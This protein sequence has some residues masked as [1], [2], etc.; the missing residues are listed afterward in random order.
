MNDQI[1]SL[2]IAPYL[3]EICKNLKNS[4]SRFLILTAETAAG[5]STAVPVSLL[6]N[7]SGK[8]LMLEPRRLAVTAIADRVSNLIGEET[9]NT[10]GYRL[11]LE[12]K[13][14]SLTRLEIVTEAILTRKLQSDP[15]LEDINV[16]VIDE[17]HERSIHADLAL[18]FLKETMQLRDDLYVII[19]SA[20]LDLR[21]LAEFCGN[22]TP[23]MSVPGRNFPVNVEYTPDRSVVSC[24]ADCLIN[25]KQHRTIL[26]FLPGLY[27]INKT[28]SQLAEKFS[29]DELQILILHSSVPL[30]EQRKI[31]KPN[32]ADMPVRVILS[33]SI[34]ETSITVPDVTLVI[35]SGLC[36][37][38]RINIALGMNQ[39]VTVPSSQF[40]AEQRTGRAGRVQ[41]GECIRLWD[42]TEI[43]PL[44]QE[45][46][47]LH[48]DISQL[49]LEC[50][51]WGVTDYKKLSWLT[52]PGEA[53]WKTSSQLL[54]NLGFIENNKI[55]EKGSAC[56][57]LGLEPRIAS[58]AYFAR[59]NDC[60]DKALNLILKYSEYS[61]AS[62]QRQKLFLKELEH[63][64]NSIQIQTVEKSN[65]S[66]AE[67]LLHGF[68]D[69]IA[70]LTSKERDYAEYQF[71]GGRKARIFG[72]NSP[73]NW[74]IA[75]EVDAGNAIGKIYS[76]ENLS[77][78]QAES[79]L[80]GK[81]ITETVTRF[82]DESSFKLQKIQVI[83]FGNIVLS[84]TILPASSEDFT[85]A[86]IGSVKKNGL[87][88]LKLND[89]INSFLLRCE[90][91]SL[92]QDLSFC[93]KFNL[94]QNKADEWLKPFINSQKDFNQETIYNALYW[95][96]DGSTIDSYVPEI[97]K[98]QNG[99][100]RK[101]HYEKHSEENKVF[102]KPV[103]EIIIQ[104]AFGCFETPEICGQKVLLKLLSPARRPLQITED[105]ANFWTTSWI[106][107]CKEMKGRY[108][109]HNWDYKKFQDD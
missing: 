53:A 80:E 55:T 96:L 81:L 37:T 79:W 40:S 75:P 84:E 57:K 106:E 64:L 82:V 54:Q 22:N 1:N 74:I 43:R 94:L 93:E 42:K 41:S 27:E 66:D 78:N 72:V 98:L 9:G 5:K 21:S 10:V 107:I 28:K 33:T 58:T 59:Q 99:L 77:D 102:I 70:K 100:K 13:V 39:L 46:E 85:E 52:E 61:D 86:V 11:H 34:A 23:V 20:T 56:L 101:I 3:N 63:R 15:L 73:S 26:V 90:F 105:L 87:Q 49:V 25:R 71:P 91:Y 67:I 92:Y 7:F 32:P 6:E 62:S 104:Q 24:V 89:K 8:I 50:A 45:P 97:L 60:L 35:D 18:A 47:I 14:S 65:P 95:Y 51:Q 83:R 88:W 103:L 31:L 44:S 30:S 4:P 29:P 17:F 19:M 16:I 2:P 69:R 36:R 12:N 38:S 109:K 68:P 76:W 48:T 108:P